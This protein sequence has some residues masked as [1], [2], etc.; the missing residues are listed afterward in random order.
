MNTTAADP[1]GLFGSDKPVSRLPSLHKT[2]VDN[3]TKLT[4]YCLAFFTQDH[5]LRGPF[6]LPMNPLPNARP[7]PACNAVCLCS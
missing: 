6:I 2:A 5:Q 1:M 7:T 4:K 3:H